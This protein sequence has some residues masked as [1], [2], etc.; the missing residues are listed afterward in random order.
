MKRFISRAVGLAIVIALVLTMAL[1]GAVAAKV[2]SSL[3]TEQGVITDL[4]MSDSCDGPDMTLFPAGTETVY[5][6]FDYSGMQGQ[7]KRVAVADGVTLYDVARPYTGAGT[8]CITVTHVAGSIPPGTYRTQ[9]YEGS[10]P[11]M[12]KLWHVRPGGPGE[13]TNLRMSISPEGPAETEFIGGTRTVWAIFDY[14]GMTE[15]E[16][17]IRVYKEGGSQADVI[18]TGVS[19]TGSGTK[20]ISVTHRLAAGFPA[21]QYRAHVVK[22]GFVDGIENWSVVTEGATPTPVPAT[23]TATPV[24]PTPTPIPPTATPSPEQPYPTPMLPTPT[25]APGQPTPTP[26]PPTATP[27]PEQPYPTPMPPTPT[28]TPEQ[29]MLTPSPVPPMTT[30]T[31]APPTP[32]SKP[33]VTPTP[34]AETPLQPTAVSTIEST[35]MPATPEAGVPSP[36]STTALPTPT[37]ALT[38]KFT[39]VPTATSNTTGGAS[40]FL[41]IAGYFGVAAVLVSLALF[42]WQRRSS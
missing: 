17:E 4:H 38:P 10:Y 36:T 34:Q 15:N 14:A 40:N 24:S 9:I 28:P 31:E 29:P 26:I 7:E 27:S 1:I 19:L 42:L 41:V 20:A 23:A 30:V 32:T 11:V 37:T 13:I 22:D 8:E 2:A 16:V 12:T 3:A 25:L 35:P 39:P 6:V 18:S 5:V 33:T 21:G